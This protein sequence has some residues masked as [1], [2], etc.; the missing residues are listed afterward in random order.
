MPRPPAPSTRS[1]VKFWFQNQRT[2]MKI[3][4][5]REDRECQTQIPHEISIPNLKS[6]ILKF[7]LHLPITNTLLKAPRTKF[8]MKE[9]N[10]ESPSSSNRNWVC[11]LFQLREKM[12]QFKNWEKSGSG[13]W[14]RRQIQSLGRCS[15]SAE[16]I[17][18][19]WAVMDGGGGGLQREV[20]AAAGSSSSKTNK[21]SGLSISRS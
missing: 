6:Y 10:V 3:K 17:I 12:K 16:L 8:K 4:R 11:L 7:L 9:F 13:C 1:A 19:A 14:R 18:T 15:W 21:G 20:V 5:E 2:H